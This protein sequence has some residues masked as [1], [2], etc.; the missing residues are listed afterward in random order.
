MMSNRMPLSYCSTG[1]SKVGGEPMVNQ[2]DFRIYGK[3]GGEAM[4]NWNKYHYYD[5]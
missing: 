2:I 1:Y 3:V 4:I 5:E